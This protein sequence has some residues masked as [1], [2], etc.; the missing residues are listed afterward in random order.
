MITRSLVEFIL[1][2]DG[3]CVM[4][5]IEKCYHDMSLEFNESEKNTKKKCKLIIAKFK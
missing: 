3:D 1:N 5:K 4:N 2:D